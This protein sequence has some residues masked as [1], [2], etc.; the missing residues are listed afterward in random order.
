M[1]GPF[2]QQRFESGQKK[3]SVLAEMAFKQGKQLNDYTTLQN[4]LHVTRDSLNGI[5]E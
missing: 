5:G 1:V 3:K 2:P 4:W